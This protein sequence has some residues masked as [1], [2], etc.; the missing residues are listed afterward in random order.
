[1]HGAIVYRRMADVHDGVAH[2]TH[3]RIQNARA[4]VPSV[5]MQQRAIVCHQCAMPAALPLNG[6]MPAEFVFEILHR[7]AMDGSQVRQVRDVVDD[8]LRV[9]VQLAQ[10]VDVPAHPLRVVP[11]GV[12]GHVV[13]RLT[14]FRVMP[15]VDAIGVQQDDLATFFAAVQREVLSE[16]AHCQR[17][18]GHLG[19]ICHHE[20]TAREGEF[21]QTVVFSRGHMPPQL[22]AVASRKPPPNAPGKVYWMLTLS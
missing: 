18:A 4:G 11:L 14:T 8:F 12:H 10:I 19:S 15:H 7:G 13:V 2:A 3:T 21:T 1:M 22:P 5:G 17:C 9:L 16:E 20:P 6:K